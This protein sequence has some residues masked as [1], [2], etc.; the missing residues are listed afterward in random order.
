MSIRAR[1]AIAVAGTL[2][3]M[4]LTF[5]SVIFVVEHSDLRGQVDTDLRSR[6]AGVVDGFSVDDEEILRLTAPAF[7]QQIAY[8]QLVDA[9]G[10]ITPLGVDA[11]TLPVEALDLTVAAG[12]SE[13][14]LRSIDIDGVHLRVLT[15]PLSPGV[16]LQ[17]ARPIDE[18]DLY[19]LRF[20]GVMVLGVVIALG[21]ALIAGF[22]VSRLAIKPIDDLTVAAEDV[23]SSHEY[24]RRIDPAGR[25]ELRRLTE[26]L[27]SMAQSLDDVLQA[28]RQLIADASHELQTPLTVLRTNV[29]LLE[30]ASE[31]PATDLA[32]ALSDMRV[33]LA[34]LSRLVDNLIDLARDSEQADRRSVAVDD[35][36]VDV[37]A[38]MRRAHRDVEIDVRVVPVSVEA[39][40]DQ[41]QR[42]V[43][44]LVE[45]AVAWSGGSGAVE[46]ELDEDGLVVRDHGPGIAPED[47]PRVFDRFY[48]ADA[49]HGSPG[50]GLGLAIVA[51]AARDHGWTVSADNAP[52]GGARFVVTFVNAP[53]GQIRAERVGFISEP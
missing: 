8:A 19:L 52:G 18:I 21:I 44:N 42:L 30:R 24:T 48:R 11:P 32:A 35:V 16:A 38:A 51:K 43:R 15:T 22:V 39:H 20:G 28:Q 1:V 23:A 37:V 6:A 40:L 26:S 53:N 33:E 12:Q 10:S 4:V 27:N 50:S 47:L 2:A 14:R 34:G 13:A 46:V 45:N 49:A 9:S 3:V 7:G 36:V 17:V 29:D 25:A 41:V 31:L 5:A